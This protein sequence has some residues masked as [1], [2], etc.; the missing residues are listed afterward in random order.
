MTEAQRL[1]LLAETGR[2]AEGCPTVVLAPA[3]RDPAVALAQT[4]DAPPH[5]TVCQPRIPA[6]A[7]RLHWPLVQTVITTIKHE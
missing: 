5:Q 1:V 3:T 2:Q 6:L 4:R 7:V